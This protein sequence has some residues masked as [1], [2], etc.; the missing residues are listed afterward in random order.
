MYFFTKIL[1]L[2]IVYSSLYL[3]YLFFLHVKLLRI[4]YT[5]FK[6]ELM[7]INRVLVMFFRSIGVITYIL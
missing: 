1:Y 6:I 3:F 4:L 5:S 2:K 7:M